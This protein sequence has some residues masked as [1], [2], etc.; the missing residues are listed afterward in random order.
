MLKE[1]CEAE[2][3][4]RE[5]ESK[6]PDEVLADESGRGRDAALG[7]RDE[8]ARLVRAALVDSGFVVES[9]DEEIA[10]IERALEIGEP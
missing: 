10:E 4:A 1:G 8:L 9:T 3:N 7:T 6:S 5:R 2:A